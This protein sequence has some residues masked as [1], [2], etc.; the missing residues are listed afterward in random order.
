MREN[1]LGLGLDL[2]VGIDAQ[3]QACLI[4]PQEIPDGD[5]HGVTGGFLVPPV[6]DFQKGM[7]P[8]GN[9]ECPTINNGVWSLKTTTFTISKQ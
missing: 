7:A 1:I 3:Q 5:P 6:V 8:I 2:L 4:A 9:R